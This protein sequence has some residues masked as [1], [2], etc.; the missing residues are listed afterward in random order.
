MQCS[1]GVPCSCFRFHAAANLS[2]SPLGTL[3]HCSKQYLEKLLKILSSF[4]NTCLWEA[5]LVFMD[6]RVRLKCSRVGVG[7]RV[8][9]QL[10]SVSRNAQ[11]VCRSVRLLELLGG[12]CRCCPFSAGADGYVL[13]PMKI[14]IYG[15]V[16]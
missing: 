7:I 1:T 4:L 6:F 11:D 8:S 13:F 15:N 2:E 10:L 9:I 3:W 12:C 16:E 14:F 5:G